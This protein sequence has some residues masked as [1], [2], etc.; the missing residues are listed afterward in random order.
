MH[1]RDWKFCILKFHWSL[2][3]RFQ[4][5]ITQHWFRWWL[6]A[7]WATSHYLNQCWAN[8]L[9]HICALGGDELILKLHYPALS[10]Q[11]RVLFTI[12]TPSHQNVQ[13]LWALD[14]RSGVTH[15]TP[16]PLSRCSP[17]LVLWISCG[18]HPANALELSILLKISILLLLHETKV[19]VRGM[20]QYHCQRFIMYNCISKLI[21]GGYSIFKHIFNNWRFCEYHLS[22]LL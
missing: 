6:G 10:S 4:W 21:Y 7:K 14:R 12:A 9:T 15:V 22:R 17:I 8:S 11:W 19:I 18:S 20:S 2:F 16:Q 3:L 5:T 1:F 13:T